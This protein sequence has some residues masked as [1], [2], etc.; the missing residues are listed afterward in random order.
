ME[1]FMGAG[2]LVAV[3][4]QGDSVHARGTASVRGGRVGVARLG[5]PRTVTVR[6][7]HCWARTLRKGAA[8]GKGVG[9]PT[10]RPIVCPEEIYGHELCKSAVHS[11]TLP[12]LMAAAAPTPLVVR[13]AAAYS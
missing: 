8:F 2:V 11:L 3:V 13:L 7:S 5:V 12:A 6:L 4:G 10:G 9:F 1:V